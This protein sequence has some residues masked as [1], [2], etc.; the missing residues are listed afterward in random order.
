MVEFMSQN[1]ASSPHRSSPQVSLKDRLLRLLA[2]GPMAT[3]TLV[4][5]VTMQDYGLDKAEKLTEEPW[6]TA[7]KRN[8]NRILNALNRLE[9]Q[10]RIIGEDL[11]AG[12]GPEIAIQVRWWRLH[13]AKEWR[14]G[15][16]DKAI[17]R[18]YAQR[19]W[20]QIAPSLARMRHWQNLLKQEATPSEPKPTC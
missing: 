6:Q 15:K 8:R 11:L 17:S 14:T 13:T 9:K 4:K 3:S 16:V 5:I 12:Q 18:R 20:P 7:Y 10:K 19:I 2:H 1:E